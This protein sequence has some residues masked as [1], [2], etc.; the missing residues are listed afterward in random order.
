MNWFHFVWIVFD[1]YRTRQQQITHS[2]PSHNLLINNFVLWKKNKHKY[3]FVLLWIEIFKWIEKMIKSSMLF[4]GRWKPSKYKFH[5]ETIH[6]TLFRQFMQS[7]ELN[8]KS[9]RI[10]FGKGLRWNFLC[11]C[12]L[13]IRYW[14]NAVVVVFENE[15]ETDNVLSFKWDFHQFW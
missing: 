8:D 4:P 5:Q 3:L 9:L 15:R 11:V 1:L 7:I 14:N 12:S 10:Y 2:K 13:S 6:K